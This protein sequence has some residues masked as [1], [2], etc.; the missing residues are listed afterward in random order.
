MMTILG[1]AS[2]F[3]VRHFVGFHQKGW[4]SP[5]SKAKD[6]AVPARAFWRHRGRGE[7]GGGAGRERGNLS[8][9]FFFFFEREKHTLILDLFL[10]CSLKNDFEC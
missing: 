5:T 10:F 7:G 2:V 4:V 1:L 3:T 9:R 8:T 6:M